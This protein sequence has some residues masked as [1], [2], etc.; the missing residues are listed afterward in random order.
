ML[1]VDSL[2]MLHLIDE[3][4]N[5]D[6]ESK[7]DHRDEVP[8]P[9]AYEHEGGFDGVTITLEREWQLKYGRIPVLWRPRQ[10]RIRD[11]IWVRLVVECRCELQVDALAVVLIGDGEDVDECCERV[12]GGDGGEVDPEAV[13]EGG[14]AVEFIVSF[15][16]VVTEEQRK[17]A[18]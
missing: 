5:G 16:L 4:E 12:D 9:A 10:S 13:E 8:L 3:R 15:E 6:G 1:F 11:V 2:P 14:E 7:D 17:E 18:A